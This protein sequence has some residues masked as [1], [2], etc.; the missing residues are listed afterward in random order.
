MVEFWGRDENK[1]NFEVQF[2][3]LYSIQLQCKN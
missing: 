2:W 3:Y 1:I